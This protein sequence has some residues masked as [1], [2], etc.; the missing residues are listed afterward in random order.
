MDSSVKTLQWL[1]KVLTKD[2]IFENYPEDI[3]CYYKAPYFF[4]MT[5]QQVQAES[6]LQFIQ[7]Q[8]GIWLAGRKCNLVKR[9]C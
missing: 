2:G 5:G 9:N 8:D 1:N 6:I 4:S 7:N 3:S